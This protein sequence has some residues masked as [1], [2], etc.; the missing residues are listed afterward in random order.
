MQERRLVI[1][2]LGVLE[3]GERFELE[4]IGSSSECSSVEVV[5]QGK[6]NLQQRLQFGALLHLLY[7]KQ[8]CIHILQHVMVRQRK[9]HLFFVFFFGEGWINTGL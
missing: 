9:I 7:G 3:F 1:G 6:H 2:G 5:T 8:N 4:P